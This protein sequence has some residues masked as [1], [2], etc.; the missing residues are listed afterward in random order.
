MPIAGQTYSELPSASGALALTGGASASVANLT[1]AD[2]SV[3]ASGAGTTLTIS[4][5][6]SLG[7]TQSASFVPGMPYYFGESGSLS[8]TG[9][10][11]VSVAGAITTANDGSSIAVTGAGS[12]LT[13]S[14]TLT[15][16]DLLSVGA[17][18][19]FGSAGG[20]VQVGGLQLNAAEVGID[21]TAAV[22]EVGT[23]GGAAAGAITVDPGNTS[24]PVAPRFCTATSS[25]TG[26]SR[27]RAAPP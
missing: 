3:S 1:V 16:N 18:E 10:A 19:G 15:L 11:S 2:G 20:T 7:T 17:F 14:G 5:A 13:A 12:S 25:I 26:R 9:G 27:R 21:T 6:L 23:T 24:P 8:V 22:L 4:G